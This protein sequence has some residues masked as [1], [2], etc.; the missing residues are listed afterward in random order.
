MF[1]LNVNVVFWFEL[2]NLVLK[3]IHIFSCFLYRV[4]QFLKEYEKVKVRLGNVKVKYFS[5]LKFFL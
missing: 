4:D 1:P 5:V 3:Y 2:F